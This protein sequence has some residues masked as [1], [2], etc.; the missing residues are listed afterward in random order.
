MLAKHSP[1]E[2]SPW[3]RQKTS[4]GKRMRTTW[5]LR[6]VSV[7]RCVAAESASRNCKV[8]SPEQPQLEKVAMN[9]A[10]IANFCLCGVV[11]WKYI[12]NRSALSDDCNITTDTAKKMK[13]HKRTHLHVR[14]H[15]I[16]LQAQ[17]SSFP[18]SD[19]PQIA[20][21]SMH[22]SVSQ[23]GLSNAER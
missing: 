2:H 23:E 19:T 11:I 10:A 5:S 8:P 16:P 22:R 1:W 13:H 15:R 20:Q 21:T 12:E 4:K 9:S 3:G 14:K 17:T 7:P 6:D 18:D